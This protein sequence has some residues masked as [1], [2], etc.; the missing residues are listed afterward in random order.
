M[1]R[2]PATSCRPGKTARWKEP[3]GAPEFLGVSEYTHVMRW[4]DKV[5][6]REAVKRGR[7]VNRSFGDPKNQLRERH[8]A[9]D[10]EVNREDMVEARGGERV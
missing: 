4:V 6:E 7:M 3:Y 5:G 2:R 9:R 8:S 1:S 10:F